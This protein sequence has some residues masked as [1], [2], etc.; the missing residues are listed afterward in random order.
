MAHGPLLVQIENLPE[1][2]LGEDG[3]WYT[4]SY[5]VV[6]DGIANVTA[7]YLLGT[8][9]SSKPEDA[10]TNNG[11]ITIPTVASTQFF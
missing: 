2:V 10:A 5:Y 7:T 4:A 9:G 11:T 6:E 8:S 3:N 1:K